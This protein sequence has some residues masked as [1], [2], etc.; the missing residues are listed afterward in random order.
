MA[1]SPSRPP[2]WMASLTA[3]LDA[4]EH[5]IHSKGDVEV[6]L[7]R[8]TE[9]L[10][11]LEVELATMPPDQR[12]LVA[13]HIPAAKARL[14]VLMERMALAR[15]KVGGELQAKRKVSHAMQSYKRVVS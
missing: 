4:L 3:A 14:D 1:N 8:A 5:A 10:G 9:V 12:A 15:D 11:Q 2:D 13:P 7:V 6:P